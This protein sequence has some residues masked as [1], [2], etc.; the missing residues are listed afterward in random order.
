MHKDCW[1]FFKN[2]WLH[3]KAMETEEG[4]AMARLIRRIA[5]KMNV[6]NACPYES[7]DRT[8]ENMPLEKMPPHSTS[9]DEEM[10][11]SRDSTDEDEEMF[12]FPN[13]D[14]QELEG[15]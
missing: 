15:T 4:D 3:C 13:N 5:S 14:G 11:M 12:P 9:Q 6:L 1:Q 8:H 7:H 2:I 10:E